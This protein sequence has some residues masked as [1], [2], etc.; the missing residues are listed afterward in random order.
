MLHDC[1][2]WIAIY[3]VGP[4]WF[5]NDNSSI[6]DGEEWY[7]AAEDG[8]MPILTGARMLFTKE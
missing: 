7:Y 1:A 5:D 3:L 4:K 6:Y 8:E 2:S